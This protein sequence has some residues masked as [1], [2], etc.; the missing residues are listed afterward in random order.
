M[1]RENRKKGPV[2]LHP[3]GDVPRAAPEL[4]DGHPPQ[5]LDGFRREGLVKTLWAQDC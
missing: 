5:G 4:E 3:K 2:G 1:T